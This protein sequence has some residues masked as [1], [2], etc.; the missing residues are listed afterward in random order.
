MQP[1]A[2]DSIY[3]FRLLARHFRIALGKDVK[4]EWVSELE[5]LV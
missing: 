1:T 2:V 3:L 5:S 4:T